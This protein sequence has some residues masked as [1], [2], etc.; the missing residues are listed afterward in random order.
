MLKEY[1]SDEPEE[2]EAA[3]S[4][5]RSDSDK[6]PELITS[7]GDFAA[8]V[9]DFMENYEMVGRKLKPV[10]PGSS[11]LDKLDTIRQAMRIKL[12]TKVGMAEADDDYE[13]DDDDDRL[14]ASYHANEKA[15][16]WDCESILSEQPVFYLSILLP[17]QQ[18]IPIMKTTLRLSILRQL[19]Q[20]Q[21]SS[22]GPLQSHLVLFQLPR[23]TFHRKI[24][25]NHS[26]V[27]I[28]IHLSMSTDPAL[29]AERN[30]N[31]TPPRI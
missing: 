11:G 7:R 29:S 13:D 28:T 4:S 22:L 19:N 23:R 17:F 3:A 15:D 25:N 31:P 21:R 27:T 8:M 20:L 30:N 5:V 26:M 10:L 9:D 16:R 24:S 18:R 6:V 1:D 14:F 12:Y 2:E